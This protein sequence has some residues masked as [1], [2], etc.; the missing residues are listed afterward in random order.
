MPSRA[1]L[2]TFGRP[3]GA[4]LSSNSNRLRRQA[5][6]VP[7]NESREGGAPIPPN[8]V[9]GDER[10]TLAHDLETPRVSTF[11]AAATSD[12]SFVA[13]P[14][15]TQGVTSTG[16]GYRSVTNFPSQSR[17]G[18]DLPANGR[19]LYTGTTAA[20]SPRGLNRLENFGRSAIRPSNDTLASTSHGFRDDGGTGTDRAIS[21]YAAVPPPS[22]FYRQ[23]NDHRSVPPTPPRGFNR[24]EIERH[25]ISSPGIATFP[26]QSP[27]RLVARESI[28]PFPAGHDATWRNAELAGVITRA[29]N[30]DDAV[31]DP[32]AIYP[33]E[34]CIFVAKYASNSPTLPAP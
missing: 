28:Q 26:G 6:L 33:P 30:T 9:D 24:Q 16:T 2:N 17:G 5:T 25:A 34:A 22:G 18:F 29:D 4:P 12:A 10:Q 31:V 7:T 32:Q 21:H 23:E 15:H 27:R 8:N 1:R 20:Q 14:K 11:A 13:V 3:G 19:Q